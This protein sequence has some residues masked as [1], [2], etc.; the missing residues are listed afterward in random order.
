M[1][2]TYIVKLFSKKEVAEKTTAFF[3]EKPKKFKFVPGQFIEIYLAKNLVHTFSIASSPKEKEL[4]ITTRMRPSAFKNSL[5]KLKIG[6][7]G[8]IDGPLGQFV[9]TKN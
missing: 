5:N 1:F 2:M 4:M 9:F 6:N 8:K 3:F 7:R